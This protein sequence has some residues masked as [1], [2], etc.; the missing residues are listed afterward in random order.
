MLRKSSRLLASCMLTSVILSGTHTVLAGSFD[1]SYRYWNPSLRDKVGPV[2]V[3]GMKVDWVD[4]KE[5]LG[6]VDHSINGLRLNWNFDEKSKI[7]IDSFHDSFNGTATPNFSFNGFNVSAGTFK[8]NVDVKD[9]QV[10]WAKYTN[11]YAQDNSRHGFMVGLKNVRIN[12]VSDQVGGPAQVTRNFNL[13]FPTLGVMFETGR[14]D[15][16]NSFASLSGSYLN[17]DKYFYDAE[18]GAR[19]FL[20]TKKSLSVTAGYRYMKIKSEQSAWSKINTTM[21]G[22]FLGV[23]KKF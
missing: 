2:A 22:P 9:L 20:D 10:V 4:A 3:N 17:N 18:I 1:V 13:T 8:T 12:V 21:S 23:E 11:E 6:I 14:K 5:Q 15:P 7:Q 19:A 16:I